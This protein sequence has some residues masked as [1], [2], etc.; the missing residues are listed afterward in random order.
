[1][2][3]CSAAFCHLCAKEPSGKSGLDPDILDDG[4]WRMPSCGS[5]MCLFEEY[6]TA[7]DEEAVPK[8]DAINIF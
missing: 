1:M 6:T 2:G 4:H 5:R 8:M 3:K 7:K